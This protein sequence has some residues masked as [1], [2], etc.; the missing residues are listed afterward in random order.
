M[1]ECHPPSRQA[2][3]FSDIVSIELPH[4]SADLGV[5]PMPGVVDLL[6]LSMADLLTLG[7]RQQFSKPSDTTA[8]GQR[9][10][11]PFADRFSLFK[12]LAVLVFFDL[13]STGLACDTGVRI[14]ASKTKPKHPVKSLE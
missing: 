7:S 5:E 6:D 8:V 14:D 1:A 9:E 11:G 10:V 3:H 4:L 12:P 2:A 13:S